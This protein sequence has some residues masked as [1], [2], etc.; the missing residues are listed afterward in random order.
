MSEDQNTISNGEQPK[1]AFLHGL[2]DNYFLML[3]LGLVV[4]ALSYCIWGVIE[5]LGT[6]PIPDEIKQTLLNP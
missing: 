1:K 6:Q 2:L 3:V 4:Y 5:I